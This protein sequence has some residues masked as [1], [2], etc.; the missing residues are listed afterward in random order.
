GSKCGRSGQAGTDSNKDSTGR[1]RRRADTR[2]RDGRSGR[3]R[4]RRRG[5]ARRGRRTHLRRSAG[6]PDRGRAP[7]QGRRSPRG[8]SLPRAG[9]QES[10]SSSSWLT[11]TYSGGLAGKPYFTAL[12]LSTTAIG[13]RAQG[14]G[15]RVWDRDKV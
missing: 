7:A 2:R 4:R 8:T 5:A 12:I 13:L 1:I 11:R 9:K 14:F 15:L 3:N 6:G 10:T